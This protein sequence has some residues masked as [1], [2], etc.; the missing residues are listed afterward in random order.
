MSDIEVG[1]TKSWKRS[2]LFR[3]GAIVIGLLPF[4]L[5]ELTLW[6]VG[7][8]SADAITDPYIGF[9]EIRPLF[10]L[11]AEGS[12]YEIA[13][14]RMPLFCEAKF[15]ATKADNEFRVFCIGGSTVQGRPFAPDTSF[16]KW[17]QLRLE[18]L[19]STKK[20]TV[21]NCGGV[22]YA[23]Y[24][25]VPIVKEVLEYEPDLI[26]LYTGQNEF[27]EDRTYSQIKTA[28]RWIGRTHDRL[29]K[30]RTYSFLRASMMEAKPQP[31]DPENVLPADVE[32]RLDFRGGLEQYERDDFWR[33]NVIEHFEQNLNG[34]V[35][36]IQAVDVPLILC[37]PVTNLRDASPFKSEH[38]SS[39]TDA[40]RSRFE[41]EWDALNQ[42]SG[43]RVGWPQMKSQLESLVEINPRHAGAH[44]RLGQAYQQLEQFESA[45]RHL[46]LAKEEDVCPLRIVEPMYTAIDRVAKGNAVS[47][48]DVKAFFETVAPDGIPGRESLLDHVHPTIFG[49]QQISELLLL[50][51]IDQGLVDPKTEQL[52]C[53]DVFR[54]HLG[55]LPFIYFELGKDRLAGLKR[56][57]E[58]KVT[59]ERTPQ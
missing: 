59:R 16:P 24:R 58:G 29:S 33:K 50:E 38:S 31:V 43:A 5:F 40:Q 1:S 22:S 20:W 46:I 10:E 51:M 21:V 57:A 36:A 30:V 55:S 35:R 23:S 56:W 32:A 14:N 7:W 19:D 44:Y 45:K 2:L 54:D 53:G 25:L 12:E 4:L 49:H 28:P 15:P 27:L 6:G 13:S 8:Q 48:V 11:S 42:G 37:N 9:T 18:T 3:V 17:L 41:S 34:M 26:V 52:D 47:V 39:M